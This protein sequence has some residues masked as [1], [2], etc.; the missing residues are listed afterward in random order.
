MWVLMLL[1]LLLLLLLL[2]MVLLLLLLVMMLVLMLV[3]W[4]HRRW[5]LDFV[6]EEVCTTTRFAFA[7]FAAMSA[8][9]H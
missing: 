1:V 6:G 5:S 4:S 7:T 3:P 2:V 8:R 9:G